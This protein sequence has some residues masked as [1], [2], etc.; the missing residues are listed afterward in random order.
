[1]PS[2]HRQPGQ[3]PSRQGP[4]SAR[5]PDGA[6]EQRR[7]AAHSAAAALAGTAPPPMSDASQAR[8]AAGAASQSPGRH[9]AAAYQQ[10]LAPGSRAAYGPTSSG[11]GPYSYLA[12][13]QPMQPL[14]PGVPAASAHAQGSPAPSLRSATAMQYPSLPPQQLQPMPGLQFQQRQ[15]VPG[16][17]VVSQQRQ[18]ASSA[19]LQH[20]PH[21]GPTAGQA[22]HHAA[23]QAALQSNGYASLGPLPDS[24]HAPVQPDYRL[25][26]PVAPGMPGAAASAY[27]DR[28][29][30]AGPTTSGFTYPPTMPSH[31]AALGHPLAT[32]AYSLAKSAM[33]SHALPPQV[34]PG[35]AGDSC[36][37][38][39]RHLSQ[40]A[41]AATR[42][43]SAWAASSARTLRPGMAVCNDDSR[44]VEPGSA[45]AGCLK[46]VCATGA[47][48]PAVY[49]QYGQ[50]H[51]QLHHQQQ[52]PQQQP[53]QWPWHAAVGSPGSSSWMQSGSQ[54]TVQRSA[55]GRQVSNSQSALRMLPQQQLRAAAG[56]VPQ[57]GQ[58]AALDA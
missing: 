52:Q 27:R 5:L 15:Q 16:A 8:A 22:A 33:R 57:A 45:H 3:P 28:A 2:A 20:A 19:K 9:P 31:G 48:L 10:G 36:R 18:R 41:M 37:L 34:V 25:H 42:G 47:T 4:L 26:H 24:A 54:Q 13:A 53:A 55:Q 43:A 1:M 12:A 39:D 17:Q 11:P 58:L 44:R 30:P 46:G 40:P 7:P 23:P 49:A 21:P 6:G 50:Q 35:S 38:A 56:M 29:G 32:P 51:H 14:V